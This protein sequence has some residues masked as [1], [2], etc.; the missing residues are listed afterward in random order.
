[1]LTNPPKIRFGKQ[2]SEPLGGFL[3]AS[4]EEEEHLAAAAADMGETS[5]NW[6][7]LTL[8]A[9]KNLKASTRAG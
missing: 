7:M 4:R 5:V 1:M 3:P 2:V 6:T 8:V 9:T